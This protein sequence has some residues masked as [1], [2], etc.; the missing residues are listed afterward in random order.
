MLRYR[1]YK[2]R[3][4]VLQCGFAIKENSPREEKHKLKT[5]QER[6]REGKSVWL[7]SIIKTMVE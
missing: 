4:K 7:I 2:E 6:E 1:I 3:E 5:Q